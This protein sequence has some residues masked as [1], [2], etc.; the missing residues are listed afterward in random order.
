M[1]ME[2]IHLRVFILRSKRRPG[3]SWEDVKPL[4]GCTESRYFLRNVKKYLIILS[5]ENMLG[6]SSIPDWNG[7]DQVCFFYEDC[8]HEGN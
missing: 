1:F 4:D 7:S 3:F 5:E 6:R 8:D 2:K